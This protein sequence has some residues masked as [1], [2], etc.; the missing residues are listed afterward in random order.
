MNN[1]FMNQS[2]A[3]K[4]LTITWSL[5]W[6][7]LPLSMRGTLL[8]LWLFGFAVLYQLIRSGFHKASRNQ[9]IG[10][11]LFILFLFWQGL[12]LL[13]DSDHSL[14]WKSLEKKSALLIIP[15]L[16]VLINQRKFNLEKWAIRG[17]FNGLLLSG[18][19]M[20]VNS[21]FRSINGEGFSPWYYHEFASPF[22]LG[23][24]YAS[25]Y[26]SA[27]LIYLVYSQQDMIITKLKTF[28]LCFFLVILLLLASKLFIILTIPV[29]LWKISTKLIQNKKRLLLVGILLGL[30]LGLSS[31]FLIRVSEL[32]NT[33]FTIL[34]QDFFTYDTPLNGITFR[35]LQ[36]RIASEILSNE[37]AWLTGVGINSNQKTLNNYYQIKGIYTGNP[38]LGDSGYLDY[39]FHNQY[40]E[41]L[42]G[43]GIPGLFLLLLIILNIFLKHEGKL[44]FPLWVYIATILFFF[45]ESV[46]D[47]QAGI[48]F[49]CL[50]VFTLSAKSVNTNGSHSYKT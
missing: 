30:V 24:I 18:M 21:I 12:S 3:D 28:L 45:T 4:I 37:N 19:Y 47:R 38:E 7:M 35:L 32:K 42:V 15:T 2:Q 49:F 48:I 29:M 10:A 23:A 16:L 43:T 46:L 44:L 41:T 5:M 9:L 22:Q 26:Y 36:W 11:G 50:I 8:L 34:R 27:A 33:D 17:F 39:N 6:F 40:L 1:Y 31:P 20:I 25:W 13:F 14:W